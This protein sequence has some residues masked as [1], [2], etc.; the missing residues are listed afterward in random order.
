MEISLYTCTVHTYAVNKFIICIYNTGYLFFSLWS[1]CSLSGRAC[2]YISLRVL[3]WWL[4]IQTT[5]KRG[6][7]C[8]FSLFHSDK[9]WNSC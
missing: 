7:F 4:V 8:T 5:A 6:T 9:L 2:A 3:V 1:F